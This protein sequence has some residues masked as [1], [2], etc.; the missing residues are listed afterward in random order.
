MGLLQP[1]DEQHSKH[2][3]EVLDLERQAIVMATEEG[4]RKT[5]CPKL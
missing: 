3:H 5:D 4:S 2:I 1:P